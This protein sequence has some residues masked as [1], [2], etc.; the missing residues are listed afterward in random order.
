MNILEIIEVCKIKLIMNRIVAESET[1]ILNSWIALYYLNS[2]V[3]FE[4]LLS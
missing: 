4:N 3:E 1:C 2:F